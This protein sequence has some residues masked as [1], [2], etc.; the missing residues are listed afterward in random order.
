MIQKKKKKKTDRT[1]HVVLTYKLVS[2]ATDALIRKYKKAKSNLGKLKKLGASLLHGVDATRM[3]YHPDLRVQKFDRI[4]FNFPH[5]GF[6][7]KEDNV[8]L[9]K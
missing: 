2:Y 4:I 7:G 9:I 8:Q 1:G 3:K 5:A 6:H